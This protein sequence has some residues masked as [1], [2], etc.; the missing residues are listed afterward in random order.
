MTIPRKGSRL[1]TVEGVAYRWSVR[2]RPTYSQ[3]LGESPMTFAVVD[4][5]SPGSTL[6]VSLDTARPDNWL[7]QPAGA[8]TPAIVEHAI[9]MAIA[10]G[11]RARQDGAPFSLRFAEAS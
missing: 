9:R 3:G 10:A 11:W 8:V 1:I 4:D 5:E 6:V 2:P 7:H